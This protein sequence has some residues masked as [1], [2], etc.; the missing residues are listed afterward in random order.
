MIAL[1]ELVSTLALG[2]PGAPEPILIRYYLDAA[3]EFLTETRA[4]RVSNPRLRP[5]QA[6]AA[7]QTVFSVAAPME[8]ELFDAVRVEHRGTPVDKAVVEG[9]SR[10]ASTPTQYQAGINRLTLNALVEADQLRTTWAARPLRT[11]REFDEAV[12]DRWGEIF[13]H[14]AFARLLVVPNQPWSEPQLATFYGGLFAEAVAVWK[15]RATDEGQIG[16]IREVAY[17]GY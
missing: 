17:G 15:S 14:G 11:A 12:T 10:G 16:V 7:G 13:E 5:A 9:G 3:R 1:H 4:L 2:A 6:A 8:Q